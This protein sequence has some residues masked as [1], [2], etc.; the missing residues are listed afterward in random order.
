MEEYIISKDAP[1]RAAMMA[2]KA[3]QPARSAPKTPCQQC[4]YNDQD[5]DT[6]PCSTCHTRN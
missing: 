5:V 6:Y 2:G 1:Q 3:E 4:Q